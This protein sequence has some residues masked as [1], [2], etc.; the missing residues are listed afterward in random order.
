[1]GPHTRTR[2][3]TPASSPADMGTGS[4]LAA[5]GTIC[6]KKRRR[7]SPR[8]WSTSMGIDLREWSSSFRDRNVNRALKRDHQL[9][10][11][12]EVAA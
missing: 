2:V 8:L 4:L 11:G 10:V 7:P 3:P 5:S 1:M 6:L 12:H 9:F